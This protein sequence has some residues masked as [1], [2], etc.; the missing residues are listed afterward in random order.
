M[1]VVGAS[2]GKAKPGSAACNA[3]CRCACG[4]SVQGARNPRCPSCPGHTDWSV[5]LHR[6]AVSLSKQVAT[7]ELGG[8]APL[9][10]GATH[11]KGLWL[12][13]GRSPG[14][15]GR[16]SSQLSSITC[17]MSEYSSK[18]LFSLRKKPC[19]FSS[20]PD[21]PRRPGTSAQSPGLASPSWD[22]RL[23]PGTSRS[24]PGLGAQSRGLVLE[25]PGTGAQSQNWAAQSQDNP[26]PGPTG[27]PRT[28][29]QSKEA[30]P[31]SWDQ[32]PRS[33]TFI[34]DAQ[35]HLLQQ[36]LQV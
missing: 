36:L 24:V 33:R 14:G 6:V 4:A 5:T 15:N 20:P 3:A 1:L 27:S 19:L 31:Q 18:Y 26:V 17:Q 30:P 21:C 7:Y 25:S 34:I 9:F 32:D 23:V 29:G 28:T 35:Q 11:G 10:V 8:R 2:P 22:E 13:Q 16:P 12:A